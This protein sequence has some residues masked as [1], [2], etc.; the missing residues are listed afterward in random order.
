[1]KYILRN[2]ITLIGVF[3]LFCL[4]SCD[5]FIAPDRDIDS[6]H[7]HYTLKIVETNFSKDY[8]TFS[9]KVK[10]PENISFYSLTDSTKIKIKTK[11]S[12]IVFAAD[13]NNMQPILTHVKNIRQQELADENLKLLILA[14]LTLSDEDVIKEKMA[15]QQMRKWFSPNNLYIAFMGQGGVTSTLPLTD[16]VMD[17]YFRKSHGQK[18]LYRSIIDK[19]EEIAQWQGLEQKQKGLIVISDGK[20]YQK[21]VPI[22]PKHYELQ[23]KLLKMNWDAGYSSVEYI[24]MGDNGDEDGDGNEAKAIMTQL[25][26]HTHGL[27]FEKFNWSKLLSDI[28]DTYDIEYADYQFDFLNP[29]NKE[30]IG[31]KT[32]LEIN[33]YNG[34]KLLTSGCAEYK[35]GNIYNPVIING[36]STLQMILQSI[37]LTILIG[38]IAFFILQIVVPYFSYKQFLKKYVTHYTNQSMMFNGIKVSQSCYFCKAPFNEGDEIVVKCKHVLHKSCWDENEYKC[39]EYGRNCKEGS[40]YYNADKLLD[41]RNSPYYMP[42]IIMAILTGWLGWVCFLF[43]TK[44]LPSE[45]FNNF[46]ISIHGL[47]LGTQEAQEAYDNYAKHLNLMPLFGF[48]LNLW[49]AFGL[50]YMSIKELPLYMRLKEVASKSIVAAIFGFLTYMLTCLI[51]ITLNLESNSIFIDWLPWVI[52]GFGVTFIA[53]YHTRI[54]LRKNLIAISCIIGIISMFA[55][56]N[57]YLHSMIDN[58]EQ[59][60]LC[61]IIY[62]IAIAASVAVVAPRSER[63]FLHIEGAIK[64]MDIALYK[65]M[66]TSPSYKVTIGKSVNSNLQMSWDFGSQIAPIQAVITQEHGRLY[67][68]AIEKGI[69]VE[70]HPLPIN[71]KIQLYHGKKFTIGKT[72]FTYIEK[73]K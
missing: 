36:M 67:L 41:S 68:S 19:M 47:Q 52:N 32:H 34:K 73:D 33:I 8:K 10:V 50:S 51:S 58:R 26:K 65:W 37:L 53:T 12:N 66:R 54:T 31:K 28:L 18:F 72:V 6:E 11:E 69:T 17:A 49:L 27:Y 43:T 25:T 48:S 15:I 61:F 38:A 39:P 9:V 2:I 23:A 64:P 29:N 45:L 22:D 60:L 16:Y 59:L 44:Y 21:D 57:L 46:I 71:Q 7:K 40:H 70:E 4:T 24:N 62:N 13:G 56:T 3:A 1:M 20:L 14:D 30:Y 35:I 55:W 5:Y 42:W 63:Y